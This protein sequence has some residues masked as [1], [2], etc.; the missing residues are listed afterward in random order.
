MAFDYFSKNKVQYILTKLKVILDGKAVPNDIKNG[1]LTIQKNGTNVQTF[2]A[3]QASNATANIT[4]PTKTS[5]LTN[6]SGYI[7]NAGVTGVKGDSESNYR[8]GN[9][10]IT[11]SNIGLGNVGNF[12]AVSTVDSQGLTDTEKANARSNIGAGT[13][14][15][16]GSYNDLSDKPTIP[17][18]TNCYQTGDTAETA[19]ADG[20]YFP[21][22]DTSA[23][24]KRK[25]LWSNIKSVLK[26]YFDTL[27]STVKSRGTPTSGGTVLSLVNTGDM[28]NW[29]N[30]STVTINNTGTASA[31]SAKYQRIGIDATYTEIEGTKYMEASTYTTPST[32]VRRF[33]FTGNAIQS[34]SVFDFYCNVFN[35]APIAVTLNTTSTT[36]SLAVDFN[37]SDNVTTCRIYIRG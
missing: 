30:K 20:D 36:H 7:T 26:T 17:S 1:K 2:T 23:T 31:S 8:S 25:T 22:Y 16:S 6:D 18:I 33:T 10:N 19:L 4:V 13:S 21:F 9:V 35:V 12:K 37:A 29:N 11:K 27:Y 14:S 32:G 34:T 15:F 24:A 3:N 5:D 28:Y